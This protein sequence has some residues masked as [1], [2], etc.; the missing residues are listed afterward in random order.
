MD[1]ALI[2]FVSVFFGGG[3]LA[4]VMV[5]TVKASIGFRKHLLTTKLIHAMVEKEFSADDIER[6]LGLQRKLTPANVKGGKD[7]VN[8]PMPPV[9]SY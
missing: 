4:I 1:V 6:V 8:Q 3:F 5:F 2:V 7:K 9:K